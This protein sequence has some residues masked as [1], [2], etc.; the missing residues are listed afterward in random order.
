MLK[1][2]LDTNIA[3]YVIKRRPIG[4]IENVEGMRIFEAL[5]WKE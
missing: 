1:Y 3:I 4:L 5:M 2:M